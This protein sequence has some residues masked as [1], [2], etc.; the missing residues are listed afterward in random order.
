[1]SQITLKLS[2]I[3]KNQATLNIGTIGHVSNGKSTLVRNLTTVVT[4]KHKEELEKNITTHLGYANAK[5][6]MDLTSGDI[7]FKP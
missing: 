6:F 1:M 3:I 2:D 4:Q 5:I 7:L